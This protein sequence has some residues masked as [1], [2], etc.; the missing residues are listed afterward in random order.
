MNERERDNTTEAHDPTKEHPNEEQCGVVWCDRKWE[1]KKK[2]L[3]NKKK[4]SPNE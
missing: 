2:E 4:P 1:K 3:R